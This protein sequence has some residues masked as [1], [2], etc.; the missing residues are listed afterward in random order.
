MC[1]S[2]GWLK[3]ALKQAKAQTFNKDISIIIIIIA[4][5][6][7]QFPEEGDTALLGRKITNQSVKDEYHRYSNDIWQ[8]LCHHISML[9]LTELFFPLDFFEKPSVNKLYVYQTGVL[10]FITIANNA[11]LIIIVTCFIS[12]SMSLLL[13]ALIETFFVFSLNRAHELNV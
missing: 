4:L 7:F 9:K 6:N 2:F 3:L 5:S 8:S 13:A 10:L 11:T 12:G 1:L